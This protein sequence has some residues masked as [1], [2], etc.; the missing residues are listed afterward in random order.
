[1]P[2][3]K[4]TVFCA[5]STDLP[6]YILS[7]LGC[8]GDA[9]GMVS[10]CGIAQLYRPGTMST[11]RLVAF[12]AQLLHLRGLVSVLLKGSSERGTTTACPIL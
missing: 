11:P 1:M 3:I 5:S 2:K 10:L 9:A 6:A 8:D 7:A 4:P 12:V